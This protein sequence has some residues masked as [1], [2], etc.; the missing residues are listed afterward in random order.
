MEDHVSV[1]TIEQ[2]FPSLPGISPALRAI[3]PLQAVQLLS[4]FSLASSALIVNMASYLPPNPTHSSPAHNACRNKLPSCTYF[5]PSYP[6]HISSTYTAH[7]HT[8]L[9]H[10]LPTNMPSIL[11][12]FT[13]FWPLCTLHS[14]TNYTAHGHLSHTSISLLTHSYLTVSTQIFPSEILP[15]VH[16][17]LYFFYQWNPF[18]STH[19]LVFPQWH[20]TSHPSANTLVS[21]V[22][23]PQH[24]I[25]SSPSR[26]SS[27]CTHNPPQIFHIELGPCLPHRHCLLRLYTMPSGSAPV[28]ALFSE[29]KF[30]F[31]FPWMAFYF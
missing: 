18:P 10:I 6:Q 5:L 23:F 12:P 2:N 14:S 16:T 26:F 20:L 7:C 3:H 4:K 31:A 29:K 30:N 24:T 17:D 8:A 15:P 25:S 19:W 21:P 22:S 1:F 28:S 11:H 13:Y 27:L 9:L